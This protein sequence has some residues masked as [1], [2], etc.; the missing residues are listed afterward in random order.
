MAVRSILH[1]LS[2]SPELIAEGGS[3]NSLV[4]ALVANPSA[5]IYVGGSDVDSTDGLEL[6][7]S[8]S[9]SIPLGPGDTLWAVAGSGT[10]TVTGRSTNPVAPLIDE[11]SRWDLTGYY[12]AP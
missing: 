2:T 11:Y 10:P 1:T 6:S 5:T 8:A 4:H 7:A 12:G 9:V 3:A